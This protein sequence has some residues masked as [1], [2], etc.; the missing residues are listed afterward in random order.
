MLGDTEFKDLR[1][2]STC[3]GAVILKSSDEGTS[4]YLPAASD[5]LE[6]MMVKYSSDD[7]I[8]DRLH[9]AE[10]IITQLRKEL[11]EWK[12]GNPKNL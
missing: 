12:R 10:I 11:A 3:G 2:C 9:R 6:R 8:L 4:Y 5:W 1:C 7:F